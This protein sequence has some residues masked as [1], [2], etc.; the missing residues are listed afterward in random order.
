MFLELAGIGIGYSFT[1]MFMFSLVLL[2]VI[3]FKY[4]TAKATIYYSNMLL[5]VLTLIVFLLVLMFTGNFMIQSLFNEL[6]R[7]TVY[8]FSVFGIIFGVLSF[9][10]LARIG[11]KLIYR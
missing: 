8:K 2:Y 4:K 3:D 10:F 5:G 9:P 1:A 7:E 6:D 11:Q